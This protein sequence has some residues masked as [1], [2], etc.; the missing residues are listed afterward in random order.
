VGALAAPAGSGWATALAELALPP[1]ALAGALAPQ[2]S[3]A[4]PQ[5]IAAPP[6]SKTW[7]WDQPPA[8]PDHQA[9]THE[10]DMFAG[11]L[12]RSPA[13]KLERA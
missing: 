11:F 5:A 13:E 2:A 3:P 9:R 6:S 8:G 12:V 1:A 4:A 7:S 10:A